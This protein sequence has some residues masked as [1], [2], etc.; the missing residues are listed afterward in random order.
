MTQ[1]PFVDD[2]G[3]V[4]ENLIRHYTDDPEHKTLLQVETGANY[5]DAVD[6]YPC[7]FTYEEID[8][9]TEEEPEP[10]QEPEQEPETENE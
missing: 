3:T 8:K 10:E 7:P 2:G 5:D 6:I 4:H 9:P 1:Y